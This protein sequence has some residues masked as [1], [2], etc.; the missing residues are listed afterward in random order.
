MN[1]GI[2]GI[3][4]GNAED[5]VQERRGGIE[6]RG[7]GYAEP[8]EP[9]ADALDDLQHRR[10]PW[11]AKELHTDPGMGVDRIEHAEGHRADRLARPGVTGNPARDTRDDV[12]GCSG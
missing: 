4:S 11:L 6:Q 10:T 2:R 5:V 3:L 8:L 1:A 7:W 12:V 9:S